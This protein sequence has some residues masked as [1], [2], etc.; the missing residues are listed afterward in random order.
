MKF[1]CYGCG[2]I[3][4]DVKFVVNCCPSSSMTLCAECAGEQCDDGY[5]LWCSICSNIFTFCCKNYGLK[6]ICYNCRITDIL[7]KHIDKNILDNILI[8]Y[9]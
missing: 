8:K 5:V 7:K 6:D 3:D 9:L 4:E 1:F 2:E